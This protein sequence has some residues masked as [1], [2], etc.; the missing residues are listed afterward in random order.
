MILPYFCG[1]AEIWWEKAEMSVCAETEFT[2]GKKL[3]C[4]LAFF[5]PYCYFGDTQKA[6]PAVA[7]VVQCRILEKAQPFGFGAYAFR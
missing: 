6:L 3:V 7:P 5:L 1:G 2:E 4:R